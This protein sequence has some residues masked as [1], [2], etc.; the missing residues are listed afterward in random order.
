MRHQR[1]G[2]RTLTIVDAIDCMEGDGPIL[3]SLKQ[4]G[5]MLVGTNLTAVDATLSRLMHLEPERI[6][7]LALANGRLG[8][9]AEQHIDERGEAWQSLVSPFLMLDREHLRKLRDAQTHFVT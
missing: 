9:L 8:P 2:G 6:P 3:G 4:M 7:Y 5:L 1:L